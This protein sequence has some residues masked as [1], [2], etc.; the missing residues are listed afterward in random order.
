M[1]SVVAGVS[2]PEQITANAAAAE[3]SLTDDELAVVDQIVNAEA[4]SGQRE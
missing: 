4:R 3:W 2:K 1:G